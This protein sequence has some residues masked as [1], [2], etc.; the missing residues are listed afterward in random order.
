[1]LLCRENPAIHSAMRW[2]KISSSYL[3]ITFNIS[4]ILRIISSTEPVEIYAFKSLANKTSVLI[5]TELPWVQINYTLHGILHH[6]N[7]LIQ[8]NGNHG[9]G[10]IS[11]EALE[12]NNKY[13]RRYLELFSRKTSPID[14]LTDVMDRLL[15]RS[16]P[17]IVN[18]KYSLRSKPLCNTCGSRKHFTRTHDKA[19]TFDSYDLVV[20]DIL[21]D[22]SEFQWIQEKQQ[23][24]LCFSWFCIIC[25]F[26]PKQ[27]ISCRYT[28]QYR[29][30]FLFHVFY[31]LGT[32]HRS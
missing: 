28:L 29:I 13:V 20:H 14:Q 4:C 21:I 16:H 15:E 3:W 18:N 25:L 31:Y 7:E 2:W 27:F 26:I 32:L 11:E 19:V 22:T 12:A 10:A 9:L 23:Y 8:R 24:V 17:D 5:A 30:Y 1:M 6:S